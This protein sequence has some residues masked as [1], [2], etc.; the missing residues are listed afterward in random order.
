MAQ[1][2]DPRA[3]ERDED[4]KLGHFLDTPADQLLCL[5]RAVGLVHTA[6]AE[7]AKVDHSAI[8]AEIGA[9]SLLPLLVWTVAHATLPHVWT[10]LEYAKAL[11]TK[12][13]TNSELGYYLACFEAA[14]EYVIVAEPS[15]SHSRP[16]TP[17]AA[18]ASLARVEDRACDA[19]LQE[20]ACGC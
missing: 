7:A 13:T 14:C 3:V 2:V 20:V 9:D 15:A 1:R 16:L 17:A 5:Y 12:E 10:A 18:D 6:A 8:G 11:A 19:A 4:A